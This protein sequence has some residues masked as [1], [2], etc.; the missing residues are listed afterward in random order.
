[1][2]HLNLATCKNAL[3]P[4]TRDAHKGLF[5]HVLIV[6]G[7]YGMGGAVCLAGTAALRS[8]AGLV[9]LVTRPEHSFAITAACPELMCHGV[10]DKKLEEFLMPLLKRA[11]VI[12]MGPGLGQAP[13][14]KALFQYVL[15]HW[16][17]DLII[18]GDGLNLL[19]QARQSRD[20]WI[21]T[22]HPGEAARLLYTLVPDCSVEF[23]QNNR[24]EA[25][26][27]LQTAYQGTVVLKGADTLI[28]GK[29]G[30]P[31][32]CTGGHPAMA[33]AGMGDVLSGIIGALVAQQMPL[34]AAA[35]LGVCAHAEGGALAA[36]GQARGLLASDLFKTIPQCLN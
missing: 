24:L 5:G 20:N 9:S 11:T 22:P 18:D 29:S 30:Q 26:Q 28:L 10:P 33:T 17:G 35:Q 36:N 8:G 34:E 6:G 23:I 2:D 13:W 31:A 25:L 7:D 16:S 3:N 27:A 12:L 15:T 14:G 19:S 1:M 32:L 21:L 4:R